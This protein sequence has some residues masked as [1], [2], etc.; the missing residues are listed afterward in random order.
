MSLPYLVELLG[1][2]EGSPGSP[3]LSFGSRQ[4]A[5]ILTPGQQLQQDTILSN[6]DYACIVY[7]LRFSNAIVPLLQAVVTYKGALIF[8]GAITPDVVA[9]NIDTFVMAERN[10]PFQVL[11][12]NTSV[13]NQGYSYTISFLRV[14]GQDAYG[15]VTKVISNMAFGRP[16]PAGG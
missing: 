8:A 3:Y 15:V 7:R 13:L 14:P 1:G 10:A 9:D 6:T 2:I 12:T 16:Y 4:V 11:W 5:G